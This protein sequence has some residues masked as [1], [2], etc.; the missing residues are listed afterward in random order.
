VPFTLHFRQDSDERSDARGTGTRLGIDREYAADR[1]R[2]FR[3]QLNQAAFGQVGRN[4]KVGENRGL[5]S[6]LAIWGP[7]QGTKFGVANYGWVI[8]WYVALIV[9]L[10]IPT[11]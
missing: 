5:S 6:G 2:P 4:Q 11:A 1:Q 8:V 7:T 3:K 10:Y 9:P